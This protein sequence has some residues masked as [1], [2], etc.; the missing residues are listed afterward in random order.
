M[1]DVP[2]ETQMQRVASRDNS[3]SEEIKSIINSQ[4]SRELRLAGCDDVIN[5]NSSFEDLE[6]AVKKMHNKYL[7]LAA[8]HNE[9]N[10]DSNNPNDN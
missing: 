3:S 8:M 5:N 7:K 1:I 2:I 10:S 6:I 4:S 9:L